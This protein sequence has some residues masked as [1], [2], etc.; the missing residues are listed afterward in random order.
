MKKIGLFTIYKAKNYGTQLQAQALYTVLQKIAGE[1]NVKILTEEK[2]I[3]LNVFRPF[4][5]NPLTVY[6]R[7]QYWRKHKKY[8]SQYQVGSFNESFDVIVIGSDELWN[9]RNPDFQHSER[10]VG[11]GFDAKRKIVY[12]MSCNRSTSSEF[13]Q[14]YGRTPFV[15][16]DAIAVRDKMTQTLMQEI[17][18]ELPMRVLDP[19]FLVDFQTDKVHE[20]NYI[21]VYGYQF[22]EK[23]IA[24]IKAFAASKSLKLISV[25]F[26]HHWC[27]KFVLCSN[28]E[29][30]GYIQGA[31]YV[32]T[33]TFH[34]T[35]FSIKY[36]KQFASYVRDN[37]KVED[38]LVHFSLQERNSSEY[39][40]DTILQNV[41]DFNDI[42]QQIKVEREESLQ[43]LER[44]V[45]G[46]QH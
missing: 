32:I 44:N 6:K 22:E 16:L 8:I 37:C 9:V 45:K 38:L 42:N 19:T 21:V 24:E 27:D 33:S 30:L 20:D 46:Q 15:V 12:A 31:A 39:D 5:K 34:G 41:I 29:F 10:Y 3:S 13:V 18:H 14:Q 1:N 11:Q 40:L 25:G 2:D 36:N 43:W 23:E 17:N 28:K 35:V 26:E 7:G 4:S